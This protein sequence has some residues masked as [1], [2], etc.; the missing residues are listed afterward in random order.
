MRMLLRNCESSEYWSSGI[1]V[2]S[3]SLPPYNWTIT[4]TRPSS[5]PAASRGAKSG[6][7]MP[8]KAKPPSVAS[9]VLRMKSLLSI[10]R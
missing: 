7:L 8:R 10:V 3:P 4:N 1:T 5:T 6:L 2:F 9:E